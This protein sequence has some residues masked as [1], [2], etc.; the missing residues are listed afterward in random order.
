M[1]RGLDD[2]TDT[3]KLLIARINADIASLAGFIHYKRR[4]IGEAFEET[5]PS[6]K[7]VPRYNALADIFRQARCEVRTNYTLPRVAR[8]FGI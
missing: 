7:V 1:L 4:Q 3:K 8:V 2:G 6:D 5:G